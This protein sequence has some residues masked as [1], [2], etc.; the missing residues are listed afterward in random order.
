MALWDMAQQLQI[1]GVRATQVAADRENHIRDQ[2]QD[3]RSE[4]LE[5]ELD[6]LTLVTEALWNLCRTRLGVSDDEL[7]STMQAV[8]DEREAT[9]AAGPL[10]CG[11][12]GAA[13]PHDMPRCQFCGADSGRAPGLFGAT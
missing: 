13:V 12:C 6:Q 9:L 3:A 10:K 2:R 8:L 4:E 5:R 1:R 7:R 11:A